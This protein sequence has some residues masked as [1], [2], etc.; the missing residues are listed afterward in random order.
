MQCITLPLPA[1]KNWEIATQKNGR[2]IDSNGR[3]LKDEDRK[4]G[5]VLVYFFL[6]L[7]V[8]GT[9]A[10]IGQVQTFLLR[11]VA[12]ANTDR[13]LEDQHDH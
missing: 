2:P 13:E 6:W 4:G 7:H 11:F 12:G 8:V 9:L 5:T 1:V 3:P 10:V